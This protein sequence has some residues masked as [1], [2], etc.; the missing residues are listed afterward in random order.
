MEAAI[1]AAFFAVC[2]FASS[3]GLGIYRALRKL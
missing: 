3:V 1:Y 2:V